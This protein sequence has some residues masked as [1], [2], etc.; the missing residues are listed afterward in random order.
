MDWKI[1]EKLLDKWYEGRTDPDEERQLKELLRNPELPEAFAADRDLI[2][3]LDEASELCLADSGFDDKVLESLDKNERTGPGHPPQTQPT[4]PP[5]TQPTHPSQTRPMHPSQTRPIHPLQTQP[6]R[7]FRMR[8]AHLLRT[9]PRPLFRMLSA[10]AL[11]IIALTFSAIWL[12]QPSDDTPPPISYTEEEIRQAGEVTEATLFLV[13]DL[14]NT[15]RSEIAR[16]SV[17]P[18]NLEKL[19]YLSAF[20][21]AIQ[22]LEIIPNQN[23]QPSNRRN[24]S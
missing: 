21:R 20:N 10:A 6:A 14:L 16:V 12:L 9:N 5:Q 3:A 11:V 1:A 18:R 7:P 13:S 17:V 23:F 19:E 24:E 4:H 15:G 8:P 2:Q 22:H